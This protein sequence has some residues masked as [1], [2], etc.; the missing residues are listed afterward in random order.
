MQSRLPMAGP[1][2]F[3]LLGPLVV[4]CGWTVGSAAA[5]GAG[6]ARAGADPHQ[7]GGGYLISVAEGQLDQRLGHLAERRAAVDGRCDLSR[8][9]ELDKGI[10]VLGA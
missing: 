5:P 1:V 9:D 6:R 8:L 10:L 4:L 3:S 7:P 2:E